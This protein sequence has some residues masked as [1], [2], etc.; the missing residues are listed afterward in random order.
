VGVQI[1]HFGAIFPVAF[2]EFLVG[3]QKMA[4]R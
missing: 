1:R 4:R 2:D 3:A